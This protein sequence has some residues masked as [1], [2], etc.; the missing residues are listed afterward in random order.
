MINFLAHS[1]VVDPGVDYFYLGDFSGAVH[2]KVKLWHHAC[3]APTL[4][5]AEYAFTPVQD[6]Y[7]AFLH[8]ND[9]KPTLLEYD[10]PQHYNMRLV[11]DALSATI[12]GAMA[13]DSDTTKVLVVNANRNA[14][15]LHLAD[16]IYQGTVD[17]AAEMAGVTDDPLTYVWPADLRIDEDGLCRVL[18]FND[19]Y[20]A[21]TMVA[22][23]LSIALEQ[24]AT[25]NYVE[26][27]AEGVGGSCH[28]DG[29]NL[30][31]DGEVYCNYA[32][33]ETGTMTYQTSLATTGPWSDLGPDSQE[34]VPEGVA[35][36]Q[37][38]TVHATVA[39]ASLPVPAYPAYLYVRAKVTY[40]GQVVYSY[41]TS[42]RTRYGAYTVAFL[43]SPAPSVVGK[44][45]QVSQVRYA[46]GQ[47][48]CREVVQRYDTSIS[49]YA[50]VSTHI[51]E[52]DWTDFWGVSTEIVPGDEDNASQPPAFTSAT[53]ADGSVGLAYYFL[54]VLTLW[55]RID[56]VWS[57]MTLPVTPEGYELDPEEPLLL[58]DLDHPSIITTI[59]QS[60]PWGYRLAVYDLTLG[61]WTIQQANLTTNYNIAFNTAHD[62]L[63]FM[64]GD[65]SLWH[66]TSVQGSNA[67]WFV[68][69]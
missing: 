34:W 12:Y 3:P 9:T 57:Q 68:N 47:L 32:P 64:S 43:S 31:F 21:E 33:G 45:I 41:I 35:I 20:V 40:N 8:T 24:Y 14:T 44:R 22:A 5:T 28:A 36:G 60:D 63:F 67:I 13:W 11:R 59:N 66:C 27:G 38:G 51:T 42:V 7:I 17:F 46:G 1:R 2:N 19:F 16:I 56:G 15:G 39:F 37:V 65:D 54:G 6:D 4:E 61:M 25:R 26:E 58:V 18:H 49:M 52:R 69:K 55:M 48:C 30:A 23:D 53:F 29:L 62:K 50:E 10:K